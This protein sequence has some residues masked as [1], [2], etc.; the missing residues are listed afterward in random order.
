MSLKLLVVSKSFPPLQTAQALQIG[1]V[2]EAIADCDCEITVVAGIPNGDKE[3]VKVLPENSSSHICYVPYS[4]PWL[5]K[6]RLTRI[7]A[8]F[9]LEVSPIN[10]LYGWVTQASSAAIEVLKNQKIDVIMTSSSP[11]E[12]HLVGLTLKR[13]TGLPWI[14]SFSD[15]W[16]G[17]LSPKP[18]YTKGLPLFRNIRMAL[19]KKVMSE[20]NIVHMPNCYGIEWTEKISGFPITGKAVVIPHIGSSTP[21]TDTIPEYV[22]WLAHV[23]DLSNE[24]VS[25]ALL[26]GVQRAYMEI[27]DHFK[28][29]LCVG[30]VCPIFNEM[31]H[32]MGMNGIVKLTGQL[33]A[34][35]AMLISR[36]VTALLVIEADMKMSPYLPSKFADYALIGKPILSIT[37]SKSS[38][39]DYLNRYGGGIAVGHVANEIFS[40]ILEI[41]SQKSKIEPSINPRKS[42]LKSP[43]MSQVVGRQYMRM[44]QNLLDG[45]EK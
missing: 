23:G 12:S 6:H 3:N 30:K 20:C 40:A 28:G 14:A 9:C 5:G 31:V 44:F 45:S 7:W 36:S 37:P 8:R 25:R 13:K 41:F 43:F 35:E 2:A 1:K 27:P 4:V 33:S 11:F 19:L 29:L 16:P 32:N 21:V 34:N 26:D 38:I 17:S 39:R 42:D 15:P 10:N 22:G 24:R 18:Y